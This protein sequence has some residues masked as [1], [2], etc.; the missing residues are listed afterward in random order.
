VSIREKDN[1]I[2]IDEF[3]FIRTC[4]ACPEQYDVF[5]GGKQQ[6]G[7]VRLRW[8]QLRAD[9]PTAGEETV[10]NAIIDSSSHFRGCFKSEEQRI[11]YLSEIAKVIREKLVE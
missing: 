10:Y 2:Y 4:S 5:L 8:S 11:Y 7:Y 6:V 1:A 3:T 9:Y